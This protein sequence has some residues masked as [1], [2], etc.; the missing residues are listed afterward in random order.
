MKLPW[1]RANANL[2]GDAEEQDDGEES[3]AAS[4]LGDA[5][6]AAQKGG[7]ER[8][9]TKTSDQELCPSLAKT[10]ADAE[11]VRRLVNKSLRAAEGSA[12]STTGQQLG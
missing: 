7:V 2:N 12:S 4:L 5:T 3:A 1:L 9:K 6:A 10:I 11:A 8:K